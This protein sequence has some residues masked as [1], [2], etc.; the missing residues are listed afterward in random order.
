MNNTYIKTREQG[1]P[2]N[3]GVQTKTYVISSSVGECSRASDGPENGRTSKLTT[4]FPENVTKIGEGS[5]ESNSLG[6]YKR[7][8]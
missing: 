8:V 6:K 3:A 2:V 5:A 1:I 4:V 7:R